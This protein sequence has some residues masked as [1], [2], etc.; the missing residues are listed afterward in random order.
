ME[1]RTYHVVFNGY[2]N[3]GNVEQVRRV[4]FYHETQTAIFTHMNGTTSVF[5]DVKRIQPV[6]ESD[7]VEIPMI[8]SRGHFQ[9]LSS[10]IAEILNEP[11]NE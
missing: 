9:S 2:D 1:S 4:E 11:D 8:L 7:L 5:T 3:S 6:I 10:R